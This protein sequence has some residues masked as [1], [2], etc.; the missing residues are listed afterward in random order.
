MLSFSKFLSEERINLGGG[1]KYGQVILLMGG[2]GSGKSTATRKYVN[3]RG[4]K[5]INPDDVKELIVRAADKGNPAFKEMKGVDPFSREG[6]QIVHRYL[7]K[8][9][10][11]KKKMDLMLASIKLAPPDKK[12]NLVLDRTFSYPREME[13]VVPG[14]IEAGY[15]PENIHIV[16]VMTDANIA[17]ERNRSRERSIPDEVVMR[18]NKG[19]RINFY[20]LFFKGNDAT[21]MINGDYYVVINRGAEIVKVKSAGQ[22]VDTETEMAEKIRKKIGV[23]DKGFLPKTS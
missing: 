17:V 1:A 12:P 4:Y 10:L 18:T 13:R 16:F 21:S 8:T 5:V 11:G 15:K 23:E 22:R 2:A 7:I 14:L 20:R 19:A 9:K 6:S 3:T